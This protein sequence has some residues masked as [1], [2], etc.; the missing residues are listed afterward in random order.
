MRKKG[1]IVFAPMEIIAAYFRVS[2]CTVIT[3]A[4][5]EARFED[6]E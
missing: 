4:W 5:V 3:K 6:S 2:M 1:K